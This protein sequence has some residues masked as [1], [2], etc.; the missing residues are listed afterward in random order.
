MWQAVGDR[1]VGDGTEDYGEADEGVR[2]DSEETVE[3]ALKGEG[4]S[5]YVGENGAKVA[6][7]PSGNVSGVETREREVKGRIGEGNDGEGKEG[8][9]TSVRLV[10]CKGGLRG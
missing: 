4:S 8:K 5:S 3:V 7:G 6:R 9:S 2:N 10:S 1:T